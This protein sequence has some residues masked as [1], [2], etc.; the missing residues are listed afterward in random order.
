M[1]KWGSEYEYGTTELQKNGALNVNMETQSGYEEVGPWI[2][3]WKHG[4]AIKKL[5]VDMAVCLHHPPSLSVSHTNT[6]ALTPFQNKVWELYFYI[7]KCCCSP[8]SHVSITGLPLSTSRLVT[9]YYY[10]FVTSPWHLHVS[11]YIILLIKRNFALNINTINTIS[12]IT[13]QILLN[14]SSEMPS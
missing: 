11:F 6:E 5:W 2:W 7:T 14:N 10:Y 13:D 8:I 9:S 1:K 3:I 4:A 12:Q